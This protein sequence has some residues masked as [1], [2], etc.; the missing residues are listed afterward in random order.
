MGGTATEQQSADNPH[1]GIDSKYS[2]QDVFSSTARIGCASY[3]GI[4][5]SSSTWT[6]ASSTSVDCRTYVEGSLCLG[7]GS[8]PRTSRL[9]GNQRR[10]ARQRHSSKSKV[11]N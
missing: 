3:R 7:C 10:Y 11:F 6:V 4:R 8:I 9:F 5:N 1:N 2:R